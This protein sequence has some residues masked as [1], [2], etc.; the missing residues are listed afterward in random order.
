MPELPEVETVKR[1]L[2]SKITGAGIADVEI[3]AAKFIRNVPVADFVRRVKGQRIGGITRRGKRL[4]LDLGEDFL[5]VHLM[6]AG[7]LLYHVRSDERAKH[8]HLILTLDNG[9]ELRY[10]DLRHFGGVF[11]H[12]KAEGELWANLGPEPLED[13]FSIAY[14]R[15]AL[16]SKKGKIKPYLL[17]QKLVV[18]LGNIY[19]DE[20][21]FR[22]GIHP[23]RPA[24]SLVEAE[25]DRLH[26]AIREI[27]SEAIAH[28]G[29][30]FATYVDGE[31]RKGEY[32]SM[33]KVYRR[34]GEPCPT[35]RTPISK[36]RLGG[37]TAHFCDVCQS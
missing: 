36:L 23:A 2:A 8:T 21:L 12:S 37:R 26:R 9:A 18:G 22:A 15:E 16:W 11:L 14:F 34:A 6:M 30:T 20:C 31:G 19:A 10:V 7:R 1:T 3:V 5:V 25:V 35:C 33:L 13:A 17:D 4:V 27:L 24:S 29:T 28:R 32:G